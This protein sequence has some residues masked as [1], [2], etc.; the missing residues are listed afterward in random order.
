MISGPALVVDRSL[1]I[2]AFELTFRA[3]R[4][5]GPGGQHVNASSTRVE[6]LWNIERSGV[7]SEP[8][9]A[10]LREKLRARLDARG[11]L[12]VVASAHRSQTRNRADAEE[13]LA[14]LV[15]RALMV[16]KTRK[17]TRPGRAAVQSRLD[18]KRIKSEKK[19]QRRDRDFD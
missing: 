1:S 7:L 4:A 13:R 6:V 8:Q 17:K 5:G 12:R 10:L 16:P 19:R 14:A 2:P 18:S 15:R 3:T 11:N 9:R